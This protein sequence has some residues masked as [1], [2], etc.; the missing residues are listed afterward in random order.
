MRRNQF[1]ANFNKRSRPL[2][3]CE[4]CGKVF[5]KKAPNQRYCSDCSSWNEY[6]GGGAMTGLVAAEPRLKAA[7]DLSGN[8]KVWTADQYTQDELRRLIPPRG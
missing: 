7:A 5:E 2:A 3:R 1:T 8:P 4:K 6:K